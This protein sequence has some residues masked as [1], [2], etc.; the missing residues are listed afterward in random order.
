MR[1]RSPAHFFA[2][3]VHSGRGRTITG[4]MIL[5]LRDGKFAFFRAA[6]GT[7]EGPALSDRTNARLSTPPVID[8]GRSREF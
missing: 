2:S 8:F 7:M 4:T 6:Y 3:V 5:D 1:W